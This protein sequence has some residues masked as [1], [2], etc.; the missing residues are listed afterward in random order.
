MPQENNTNL[1]IIIPIYDEEDYL[2]RLFLDV[3]KYFNETNIEVIAV[4]DGSTDKSEEILENL[5]KNTFEF[6]YKNINLD[7]NS[8]KGYALR[9]GIKY[10]KGD[11][12]LLHDA[13]LELDIKDAKEIY[14]IIK[15]DENI[16]CV[17]GSRYLSGKLKKHNYFIN[18]FIGKLN[19]FIFNILF[20]QSL[21]DIHCG[22]KIFHRDVYNKLKL[23]SNDFGIEID[24]ASQIIKNNYY[25]YE[26]GVS[27][28][29]R[30]KKAG[31]KITWIDGIKSYYYLFKVRFL[32]N[33]ISTQLSI[34]LSSFYMIYVGSHF[35][36]GL[37]N[38][39]FIVIFFVFGL[40]IGLHTK[41][42]STLLIF[43]FIYLGSLFGNGQ[44]KVLSVL[45]FFIVGIILTRKLKSLLKHN[46]MISKLF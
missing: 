44:G 16:K 36:M 45:I 32:D 27:Y 41:I 31:K 15:N 33:T 13:D 9:E 20:G 11:Y 39:L 30:S 22:L 6:N 10:S 29:S 12:I 21:S 17:F 46:N 7:K 24:L 3:V 35:G 40:I 34:F 38:K 14:E 1:S 26:V 37:G 4:N 42:L 2:E 28:F 5:K 23:T 8:G 43:M 25:I 18:E 19:T